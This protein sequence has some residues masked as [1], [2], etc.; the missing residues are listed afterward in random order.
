MRVETDAISAELLPEVGARL[1]R[2]RAFGHDLLRT[3]DDP[4]T[5]ARDPFFWGAY[6]LAP[7]ANR[8]TAGP[9]AAAGRSVDLPT[10]FADGSAIHGQVYD[11]GWHHDG[12]RFSIAAGGDGWPW[13]YEVGSRATADGS[14]LRLT[15]TLLNRSDAPMPAGLGLHPWWRRPVEVAIAA[16]SVYPT[17]TDS[18]ATPEPV[19]GRFD[20]RALGPMPSGI[21]A[22]WTD[23]DD[24]A[25]EL[26]W[27]DSG[28]ALTMRATGPDV[29]VVAASPPDLDA[30]A[31]EVQTHAPQGLRRIERREPG[32]LML[33]DPGSALSLT[34][35]LIARRGI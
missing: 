28:V 10:N 23:V 16:R 27:P 11:R 9:M 18:P 3:P 19:R 34:I 33:L 2:L 7:W 1:H 31:V 30:V 5:H 21:D 12:E 17:T 32:A 24:P 29:H 26:R 22:A 15:Y 6:V 8:L 35:E 4:A 20:R 25:V 13:R 14:T